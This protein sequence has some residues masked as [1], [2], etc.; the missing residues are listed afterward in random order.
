MQ[1]RLVF[2]LSRKRSS[3]SSLTECSPAA[4]VKKPRFDKQKAQVLFQHNIL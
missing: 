4:S 3:K 2:V 1:H